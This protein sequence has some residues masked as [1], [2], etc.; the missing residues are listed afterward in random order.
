MNNRLNESKRK[1][2]KETVE[3]ENIAEERLV[4]EPSS[5]KLMRDGN[6]ELEEDN[7]ELHTAFQALTRLGDTGITLV[8]LH[9]VAEGLSGE[10]DGSPINY[11]KADRDVAKLLMLYS[12]NVQD[13]RVVKY[14]LSSLHQDTTTTWKRSAA[15]RHAKL[16]IFKNGECLLGD[17]LILH[18]SILKGLEI[19]TRKEEK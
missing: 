4:R 1:F 12:I 5:P 6:M 19:D 7:P 14:F 15:L 9:E 8:C 13:K 2:D 17:K 18:I 11:Q 3:A 16:A 10:P